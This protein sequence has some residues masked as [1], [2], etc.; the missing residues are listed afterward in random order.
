MG[1]RLPA[2]VIALLLLAPLRLGA[3]FT[4]ASSGL[5][6]MP[7]AQMQPEGTFMIT[8][9]S[10]NPRSL[11]SSGWSYRTF[12]YGFSLT[13][14]SRFEVG[15]VCTIFDGSKVPGAT[16]RARLMFNQDRHFT[17]RFQLLREE[18]FGW[19]WMPSVVVGVSDPTTASSANG[20][21]DAAVEGDGNGY[22][23]R[24]YVALSKHFRTPWGE[25]GGHL[26]YQYNRRN[27]YRINGPAAG[28]S[29]S[30][31]LLSG[32]LF[33]DE[34]RLIAEYDSRTFNI[35]CIASVWDNRFEAMFE[36]QSCR[37]VNFGLRYKLR[38]R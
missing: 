31:A 2:T 15:Y 34:V 18:E 32:R 24:N 5:L 23:N 10:L 13:F 7:S 19:K 26:A 21:V 17:G 30:P 6:Q 27:D 35:G 4:D 16:G 12:A 28:V 8:D 25:L 36:L 33:L 37:Y 11:P 22:F 1:R 38:L 20:Y 9:N 14:W 3:Q 29:F